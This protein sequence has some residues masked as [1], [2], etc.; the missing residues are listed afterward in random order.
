[1]RRYI[2]VLEDYIAQLENEVLKDSHNSSRPPS[3]DRY[4]IKREKK[5]S[6]RFPGGQPGHMGVTRTLQVADTTIQYAP[7]TCI[8]CGVSFLEDNPVIG[9]PMIRQQAELAEKPVLI[10]QREYHQRKCP[11]CGRLSRATPAP[12]E[13]QWLGPR[14]KALANFL[15]TECHVSNSKATAFFSEGLGVT[16]ATGTWFKTRAALSEALTYSTRTVFQTVQV[17][18]EKNVDE[19][20]W[21]QGAHREYL[22]TI[23]TANATF[24]AI[25]P[26]RGGIAA[27]SLLGEKPIGNITTDRFVVYDFIPPAQHAYCWSHLDRDFQWFAEREDSE[28]KDFGKQGL[29]AVDALFTAWRRWRDGETTEW[30]Y[31]D[32]MNAVRR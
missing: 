3:S 25:L 2:D 28:R 10:I 19:T 20:S 14:L 23:S 29:R 30:E 11:C 27:Q 32:A 22:W 26:T 7:E 8:H 5:T 6:G 12:G 17:A 9:K 24:Y 16:A 13:E 15:T 4:P 18:S 1:M 21:K 31:E